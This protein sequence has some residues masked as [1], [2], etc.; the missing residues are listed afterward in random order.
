MAAVLVV[1]CAPSFVPTDRP[2]PPSSTDFHVLVVGVEWDDRGGTVSVVDAETKTA[3]DVDVENRAEAV[4]VDSTPASIA[5]AEYWADDPTA[6]QL[7]VFDAATLEELDRLPLPG[8]APA[9]IPGTPTFA[10]SLDLDRAYVI[11]SDEDGYSQSLHVIGLAGEQEAIDPVP[12]GYCGPAFVGIL[13]ELD[14]VGVVCPEFRTAFLMPLDLAESDER[15]KIAPDN[16]D[17][18]ATGATFVDRHATVCLASSG[19]DWRGAIA[20]IEANG[21]VGPIVPIS[22]TL[23]AAPNACS[24]WADDRTAVG[25]W[26]GHGVDG[27][28]DVTIVSASGTSFIELDERVVGP[29]TLVGGRMIAA[30]ADGQQALWFDES[31]SVTDMLGGIHASGGLFP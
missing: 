28:D 26:E 17:A 16:R 6:V 21:T 9:N 2:S 24:A 5:V 10:L 31:G 30:A 23:Q 15:I 7:R 22:E 29:L 19:G 1:A 11:V 13:A 27:Y 18:Y 20:V 25:L 4:V 3:K 8:R 12:L 14:V